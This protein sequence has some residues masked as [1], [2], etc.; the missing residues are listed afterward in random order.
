MVTQ[1][2]IFAAG[3]AQRLMP[4]TENRPKG[5][6]IVG[7]RPLLQH[8]LEG[9][10]EH[11]VKDVVL[12]VGHQ[13]EKI[14]AFFKDGSDFGVK[15]HYVHQAKPTG[16]ID[17]IRLALPELDTG[18]SVLLLPGHAYVDADILRPLAKAQRTTILVAT[19]GDDHTQGIP[20]VRGDRLTAMH[21]E[22]PVPGSTRVMTNIVVAD[23]DL[24]AALADETSE[25]SNELDLFLGDWASKNE[26]RVASLEGP[27]FAVVSPWDV[28]RLN[29]WVL[30]N[31]F[32]PSGH[33][34][35]KG[36]R[37][38]VAIGRNCQIAPTAVL[39][40]P[41][42]IG[43]GCT[44]ADRAIVGPYVSL[45]NEC[46]VGAHSELRR[47]ILNNNVI[48]DTHTVLRG[49][50][51]DDGVVAGPA[52]ICEEQQTPTGPRG[53][54]VG[55]DARLPARTTLEGGAIVP[56]EHGLGR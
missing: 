49:C 17:A 15:V 54:I 13:A 46:I 48:L 50:I 37:G 31:H 9:L 38:K 52:L 39:I 3:P 33:K 28:L 34:K 23:P 7:G 47:T 55:R 10:R 36:S 25:Q 14:Q 22:A 45:R 12:V 1:A 56:V 11:G 5:M 30:E 35:P 21:H 19:A 40:G 27:W 41:V 29:E 43:D 20:S 51:V 8:A 18:K 4:L 16:T 44:I 53:C 32:P 42:S 6:L 2:L 24:L 26:V